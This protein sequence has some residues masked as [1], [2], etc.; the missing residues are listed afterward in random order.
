M[1]LHYEFKSIILEVEV[2]TPTGDLRSGKSFSPHK[3]V[4]HQPMLLYLKSSQRAPI[5]LK[6]N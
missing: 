5:K 3:D 4:S 1:T 6:A 2:R